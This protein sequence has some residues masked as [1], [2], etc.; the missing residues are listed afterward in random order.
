[1]MKNAFYF[2]LKAR[3]VLEVFQFLF[4]IF[5]HLG[6]R[7]DKKAKVN[8]KIYDIKNWITNSYN[9]YIARYLKK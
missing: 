3:F 5:V 7:L 2:T 4:G 6:K 1:M 9:T 8:I